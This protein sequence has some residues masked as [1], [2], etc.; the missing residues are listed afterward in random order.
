MLHDAWLDG[1]LEGPCGRTLLSDGFIDLVGRDN[2]EQNKSAEQRFASVLL[3]S[4]AFP[5]Q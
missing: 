4:W 5:G 3:V 1:L 2:F